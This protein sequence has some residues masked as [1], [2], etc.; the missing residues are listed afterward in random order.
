MYAGS[1]P[2]SASKLVCAQVV[3]L[4]DTGDLKSPEQCVRA[5]SSPA[6]GTTFYSHLLIK[7]LIYLTEKFKTFLSVSLW[8]C[9]FNF[10]WEL[11]IRKLSHTGC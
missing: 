9:A 2:T 10:N 6:P 11:Q 7:S 8:F 3:E 1:I 4:V 5:G